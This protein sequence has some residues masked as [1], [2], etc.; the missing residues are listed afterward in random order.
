MKCEHINALAFAS[1]SG[2]LQSHG[3]NI[4]QARVRVKLFIACFFLFPYDPGCDLKSLQFYF[5]ISLLTHRSHI[6][7]KNE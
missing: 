5:F 4:A 2:S 1:S 7:W 6:L 3:N